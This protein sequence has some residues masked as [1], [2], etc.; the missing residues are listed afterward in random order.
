MIKSKIAD[1]KNITGSTNAGSIAAAQF[2]QRFVEK[3]QA[4]A[5]LDIAGMAWQDGEQRAHI[6]SWGTGFGV[7]L[8]ERLVAEHYEG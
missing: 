7:R 2:L 3:G 8:L 5:H 6:P 1:M 4:W